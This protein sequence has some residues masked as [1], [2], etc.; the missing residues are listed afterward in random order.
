MH[1]QFKSVFFYLFLLLFT[2]VLAQNTIKGVVRDTKGMPI[3]GANVYLKGTYDGSTSNGSGEFNFKT[4]ETGN[5][6]LIVSYIS[7]ETFNLT[8]DVET[9]NSLIIELK[10][11]VNTLDA[12]VLSAGTFEAG[13]NSKISVLKPLD[14]VTTASAVGD[15]VAAEVGVIQI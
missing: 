4:S 12:V 11:D 2:N 10:E 14:V 6:T 3:V 13:D 8:A 5:Q 15:F 7:F 9:M 1:N